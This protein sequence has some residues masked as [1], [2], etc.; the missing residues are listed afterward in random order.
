MSLPSSRTPASGWTVPGY[1]VESLLG[2]GASGEVWQAR[3]AQTGE[4]VALK[5]LALADPAQAGVARAEAA[6]LSALNHPHLIRLHE[7]VRASD[8]VVLVL[9]LADAGSLADCYAAG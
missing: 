8:A 2:R 3:V 5:R 9:D 1:V 7:L 4:P 6:V